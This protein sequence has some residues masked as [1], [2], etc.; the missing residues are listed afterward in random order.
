[1]APYAYQKLGKLIVCHKLTSLNSVVDSVQNK[2]WFTGRNFEIASKS[3]SQFNID[4]CSKME[5]SI[6]EV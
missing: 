5:S 2:V 6:C 1:M 4:I 3:K